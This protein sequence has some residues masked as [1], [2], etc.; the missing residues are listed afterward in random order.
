[1]LEVGGDMGVL[2]A[3]KD[4]HATFKIPNMLNANDKEDNVNLASR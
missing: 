4:M 3:K 1:M 2:Y